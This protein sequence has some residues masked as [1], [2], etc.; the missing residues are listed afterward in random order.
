ML[1]KEKDLVEGSK[2]PMLCRQDKKFLSIIADGSFGRD[3]HDPIVGGFIYGFPGF[4]KVDDPFIDFTPGMQ[5]PAFLV[6]KPAMNDNGI[7][8]FAGNTSNVASK[9]L[10]ACACLGESV[11]IFAFHRSMQSKWRPVHCRPRSG[12]E[13]SPGVF[14]LLATSGIR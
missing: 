12:V 3:V 9:Q 13:K 8:G 7:P 11:F 14:S 2:M 5:D 4:G 1:S 10:P 6:V